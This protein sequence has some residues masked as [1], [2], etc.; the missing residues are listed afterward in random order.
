M[1]LTTMIQR[2]EEREAVTC[3]KQQTLYSAVREDSLK[4]KD[5]SKILAKTDRFSAV[6]LTDWEK[7]KTLAIEHSRSR[8]LTE[9]FKTFILCHG[10]RIYI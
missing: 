3:F 5:N 8:K 2:G 7:G 4:C 6:S 1:S 10:C 9:S